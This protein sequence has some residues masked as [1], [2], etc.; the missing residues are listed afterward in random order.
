M[1][2]IS[3]CSHLL[4]LLLYLLLLLLLLLLPL[5][6]LLLRLQAEVKKYDGFRQIMM[7][8][9]GEVDAAEAKLSE[10][11]KPKKAHKSKSNK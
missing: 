10:E 3:R 5:L 6:L 1:L 7:A 2:L 9:K 4:H 8:M 11:S